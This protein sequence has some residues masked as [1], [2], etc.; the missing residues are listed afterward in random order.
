MEEED[1]YQVRTTD[2]GIFFIICVEVIQKFETWVARPA[3][4]QEHLLAI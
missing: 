1:Y 2:R 3:E 4:E